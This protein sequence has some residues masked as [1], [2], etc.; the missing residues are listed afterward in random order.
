MSHRPP[1]PR[2]HAQLC[3]RLLLDDDVTPAAK[4]AI[5]EACAAADKRLI[6]GADEELQLTDVM[7]TAHRA[8]AGRPV[9]ADKERIMII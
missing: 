6:D 2:A 9:Q 1:P 4:A 5:A 8:C 7:E 3:E